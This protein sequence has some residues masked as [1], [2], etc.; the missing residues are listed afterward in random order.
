VVRRKRMGAY[1]ALDD[2]LPGPPQARPSLERSPHPVS[3]PSKRMSRPKPKRM[4]PFNALDDLLPGPGTEPE[5]SGAGWAGLDWGPP[6]PRAAGGRRQR[7]GG[8]DAPG[9]RPTTRRAVGAD[10]VGI[11]DAL[12]DLLPGPAAPPARPARVRASFSI[13]PEVLDAVRD[14]AAHVSADAGRLT[15]AQ[16]AER[17]LRAEV[18]RLAAE[19]NHGRPFPPRQ[20][21]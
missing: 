3:G 12:D 6:P 2:L 1:N 20:G 15:P 4:G 19:H 5:P 21:R 17:A 7:P 8:P 11:F 14:A 16:L 13:P 9:E 10:R 18:D